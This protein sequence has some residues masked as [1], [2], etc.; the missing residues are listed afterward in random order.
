M[1]D[2]VEPKQ[3]YVAR[4]NRSMSIAEF[5]ANWRHHGEL[6]MSLPL[7][8][9]IFRYT[10]GDTAPVPSDIRDRL[11]GFDDSFDGIATVFFNDAEAVA[12]IPAD[13]DHPL[14]LTDEERIFD[15]PVAETSLFTKEIVEREIEATNAKITVFLRR[16][17][18]LDEAEFETAWSS[19][20]LAVADDRS[21]ELVRSYRRSPVIGL[22]GITGTDS[23]L[24]QY[25]GVVELGFASLRDL[26]AALENDEFVDGLNEGF[27]G[28]ADPGS[29]LVMVTTELTL[30]QR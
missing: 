15:R 9:N 7:W 24:G 12:N 5:R 26:T 10:Q 19:Q 14:L 8:G 29:R 17:D 27:T 18:G 13:P 28:F 21:G 3:F 4:R 11:V 16:A 30:H 25:D 1:T 22:P 6:A 23:T 2:H 20:P